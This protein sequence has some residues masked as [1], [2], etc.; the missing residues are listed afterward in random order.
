MWTE[1]K[2]GFKLFWCWCCTTCMYGTVPFQSNK[3]LKWTDP[4]QRLPKNGPFNKHFFA[5]WYNQPNWTDAG[6]KKKKSLKGIAFFAV[7]DEQLKQLRHST[8]NIYYRC[9]EFFWLW[10]VEQF[11]FFVVVV[12]FSLQTERISGQWTFNG[13]RWMILVGPF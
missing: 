3:D 10:F 13:M 5:F 7:S 8:G 1:E 2:K 6:W 4:A 11:R 9:R 12:H